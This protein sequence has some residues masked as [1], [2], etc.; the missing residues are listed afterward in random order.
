MCTGLH[1]YKKMLKTRDAKETS[2]VNKYL[3]SNIHILLEYMNVISLF[4]MLYHFL[5]CNVLKSNLFKER[6]KGQS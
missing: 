6:L 3:Y 1:Y 4:G 5:T 2:D